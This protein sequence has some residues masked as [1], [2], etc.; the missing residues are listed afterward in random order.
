MRVW[1]HIEQRLRAERFTD[2]HESY[3]PVFRYPGP[4]ATRPSDLAR[5]LQ[6][7]RQAINHLLLQLEALGYIERRAYGA[8]GRRLIYLTKP[9]RELMDTIYAA[10]RE[11]QEEWASK[12]GRKRFGD[13][14][15]VLRI[16]SADERRDDAEGVRSH[17]V[18]KRRLE[19]RGQRRT[20]AKSSKL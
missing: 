8:N 18:K 15:E 2:L 20:R 11:L 9:G 4:D 13:F 17:N 12:V 7:S 6:M 1:R 14:M 16:L 3:L 10:V 5:R 19:H